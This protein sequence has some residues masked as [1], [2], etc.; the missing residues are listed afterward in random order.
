MCESCGKACD[1]YCEMK[2]QIIVSKGLYKTLSKYAW[3]YRGLIKK[4]NLKINYFETDDHLNDSKE[5]QYKIELL[6][7]L[8]K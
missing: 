5:H 1:L 6:K 8:L 7:E 3:E 2:G 4:I